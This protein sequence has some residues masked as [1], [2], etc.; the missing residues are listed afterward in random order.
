MTVPARSAGLLPLLVPLLVLLA[1][2]V[3]EFSHYY[4]PGGPPGDAI[5]AQSRE[6]PGPAILQ[7]LEDMRLGT[8]LA[9]GNDTELVAAADALLK[10]ELRVPGFTPMRVVLPFAAEDLTRV[11]ASLPFGS[12]VVPEILLDAYTLS[13]REAYFSAA[14]EFILGFARYE[15]TAWL[16]RGFLWNDHAIATR[17]PI[18]IKFWRLYR[19]RAD[20]EA[21]TGFAV[22]QLL[23]RSGRLLAKPSHYTYNTNHG[24]MQNVGLL[25]LCAG[26]PAL[27]DARG[28]CD[29][30]LDRLSKQVGFFISSEGIVLEHSAGYHAFGMELMGM[31]LR[32]LTLLERP[33]PGDWVDK[34]LKAR[35]Y[36]AAIS[37]PDAT[38][39][40]YGDTP[41]SALHPF[42]TE[43]G[44][45]GKAPALK[46]ARETR[47]AAAFDIFPVSGHAVWW[48]GL[49]R[50]PG[51]GALAQTVL[52]WSN[53][54][55][56]GHKV[57]DDMSVLLW[58]GGQSWVT[59]A[60]YWPYRHAERKDAEGWNASNAP[61]L[62]G[63]APGSPRSTRLL[64]YGDNGRITLV[65]IQREGPRSYAARRQV[66]QVD[67][68]LWLVLD[69]VQGE[70]AATGTTTWT[71]HPS[72]TVAQGRFEHGFRIRSAE[73]GQS[74]SAAFLGSAGMQVSSLR[75]SRAP[76]AGWVV[77][78]GRPVAAP[79]FTVEQPAGDSWALALWAVDGPGDTAT[80]LTAPPRMIEWISADRWTLQ[81]PLRTG[82]T[83]L[84]RTD[85]KLEVES[86]TPADTVRVALTKA[87]DVSAERAVISS[88]LEAAKAQS[89]K[90]RNL[91]HYRLKLTWL[92]LAMLAI[93][94]VLRLALRVALRKSAP[95]YGVAIN[96]GLGGCWLVIGAWIVLVYL[97]A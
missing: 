65:D 39:P 48:R 51:S 90:Y 2:W 70:P 43:P 82:D 4:V 54:P 37:R 20:F 36:H 45:N 49:E 17:I 26:F 71:L 19:A 25:Y 77:I 81:I 62:S 11:P 15:R 89:R 23:A 94:E 57:A 10:G 93:Q 73:T 52:T 83:V 34:Y 53:F 9:F 24:V 6:A 63:E 14:R 40:M 61:H 60:G 91:H 8:S 27:P 50:W 3:P 58:S 75:G 5:L 32:C 97:P 41:S 42:V 28:W 30:A 35:E 96:L 16:D 44:E 95:R 18:L 66:A 64:H 55:G 38:L 67:S 12:F 84:R 85:G 76:F 92:I 74:M 87:R 80:T 79:A 69:Q 46:R 88:A 31:I 1:I 47:P 33:P 72:L 78:D 7:A 56:H 29:L 22:L 86:G 13:G 21:G 59:N 68:R